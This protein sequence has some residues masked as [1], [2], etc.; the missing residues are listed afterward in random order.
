MRSK[1]GVLVQ[2]PTAV[3]TTL[4]RATTAWSAAIHTAHPRLQHTRFHTH[5]AAVPRTWPCVP[6]T[7]ARTHTTCTDV[8][9]LQGTSTCCSWLTHTFTHITHNIHVH[10]TYNSHKVRMS[11]RRMGVSGYWLQLGRGRYLNCPYVRIHI[12]YIHIYTYISYIC[13]LYFRHT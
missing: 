9:I 4:G 2:S 7:H 1:G 11:G 5:F 3:G 10:I 8:L 12:L 6:C 13:M